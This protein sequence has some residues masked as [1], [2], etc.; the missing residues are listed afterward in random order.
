MSHTIGWGWEKWLGEL[1]WA[2]SQDEDPPREDIEDKCGTNH[3]T[4][5]HVPID[6][7]E[8]GNGQS[9]LCRLLERLISDGILSGRNEGGGVGG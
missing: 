2:P 1:E 3:L 8:I 9:V 5:G 7:T 6:R 4:A